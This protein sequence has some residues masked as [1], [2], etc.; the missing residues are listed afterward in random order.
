VQRAVIDQ[1][2][3]GKHAVLL[4]GDKEIERIVSIIQLPEGVSEGVWIVI[5]DNDEFELDVKTIIEVESRIQSKLEMLRKRT[6]KSNL[7]KD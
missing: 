6:Q 7:K 5:T 1:I 4:V 3:D 2:I